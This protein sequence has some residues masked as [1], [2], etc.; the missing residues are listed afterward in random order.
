MLVDYFKINEQLHFWPWKQFSDATFQLK[1]H[2]SF[3]TS[4][5]NVRTHQEVFAGYLSANNFLGSSYVAAQRI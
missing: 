1:E 4:Q 2:E 5:M 3:C